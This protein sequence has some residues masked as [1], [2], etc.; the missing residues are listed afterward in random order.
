MIDLLLLV[1]S[2]I[3]L[4]FLRT[5]ILGE[6]WPF[7]MLLNNA[8]DYFRVLNFASKVKLNKQRHTTDMFI[9]SAMST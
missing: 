2:K 6:K 3:S 8:A 1:I 9:L 4:N 7:T 5:R